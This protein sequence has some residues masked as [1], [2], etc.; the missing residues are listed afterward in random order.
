MLNFLKNLFN[1]E[2]GEKILVFTEYKDTLFYLEE[3]IEDRFPDKKITKIY[4]DMNTDARENA[5]EEFR[6]ESNVLLATDA[7]GEGINLQFCHIMV[8][9]ELP[10]NPNRIDQRIGR[11]HRYGQD[12]DVKVFNL[13]VKDTVEGRV[14]IRLQQKLNRIEQDLGELKSD[15]LGTLLEDVDLEDKV[16][17]AVAGNEDPEVTINDIEEAMEDRKEMLDRVDSELLMDLR[18]FDLSAARE[19]VEESKEEEITNEDVERFVRLFFRLHGGKIEN[20]R[21]K[22]V[23][24]ITPPNILRG[25]DEIKDQYE[26]ACF[27]KEVAEREDI[28]EVAFI[29]FGHPLLSGIIQ[30]LK[31]G[32]DSEGKVSVKAIENSQFE[33][34]TGVLF[35]FVHRIENAKGE[36]VNEQLLSFFVNDA[37]QIE[38]EITE[39]LVDKDFTDKVLEMEEASKQFD[40]I[41]VELSSKLDQLEDTA[42]KK[43]RQKSEERREEIQEE[44][45]REVEI[46]LEDAN[47][48]YEYRKGRINQRLGEYRERL[49]EGED[50]EV[51]IRKE[52]SKLEKLESKYER[53]V[54]ELENEKEIIGEDPELLNMSLVIFD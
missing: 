1:E 39:Y 44:T 54:K 8:N 32:A 4:G 30:Y 41:I 25:N 18:D 17:D 27:K 24:R 42:R 7:A 43:A 52:E 35:N 19:I 10:W 49:D 6:E 20:T 50:M 23:Y 46:R 21:Y 13:Q 33:G 9:Y 22:E 5:E 12:R 11:L 31:G 28:G 37:G 36:V 26:K 47:K 38:Q 14:F 29:A 53:R 16:M 45:E 2:P 51:L 34:K 3:L 48:F 40:D 15:I